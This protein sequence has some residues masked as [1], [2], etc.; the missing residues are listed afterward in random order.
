MAAAAQQLDLGGA[1]KNLPSKFSARP[2][3]SVLFFAN[4]FILAS[5]VPYIPSVKAALGLSDGALGTL[6]LA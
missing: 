6:L 5:W 3:V 1:A 4:G 2:A